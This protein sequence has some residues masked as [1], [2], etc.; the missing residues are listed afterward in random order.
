MNPVIC[1]TVLAADTH[2]FHQQ[3]EKVARFAHRIQIDL[4]DGE[5]APE[6]TIP[7]SDAWWPAA[8]KADIHLMYKQPSKI[9]DGLLA[10]QPNLVIVHAEADG[11][12]EAFAKAC[13]ASGAKVGVALLQKTNPKVIVPAL[14]LIDHVL[15]FSGNLGHYG[16]RADLKLLDKVKFLKRSKNGLEIGWDG[17]IDDQN[18]AD[19]VFGG[20]DVLNVGA[21]IQQADKPAAAFAALQRIADETG[22]T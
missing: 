5:F 12:F 1:P 17:G 16:G 10:H 6:P 9:L 4:T 15:I 22:T 8:V 20:V 21:F 14:D 11:D 3:V 18:V 7:A 19:L 13:R 2:Q